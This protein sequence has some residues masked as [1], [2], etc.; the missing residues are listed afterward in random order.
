MKLTF[1]A[2]MAL[3]VFSS[4]T[5][6]SA[7]FA[8]AHFERKELVAK[9]AE[10]ATTQAARADIL[11]P[12]LYVIEARLIATQA[13]EGTMRPEAAIER[14]TELREQQVQAAKGWRKAA[15]EGTLSKGAAAALGPLLGTEAA[16][17]AAEFWKVVDEKILPALNSTDGEEQS[18]LLAVGIQALEPIFNAHQ[19]AVN[20]ASDELESVAATADQAAKDAVSQADVRESVLFA[21][22]LVVVSGI[23][24]LLTRSLWRQVGAEPAELARITKLIAEGNLGARLAYDPLPGS[25]AGSI[26]SMRL[27]LI[28]VT[29]R[30]RTGADS[31]ALAASQIAAGNS[32]LSARTENQAAALEQV[33]AAATSLLSSVSADAAN[34]REVAAKAGQLAGRAQ[35]AGDKAQAAM[36]AVAQAAAQTQAIEEIVEQIKLLSFQTNLLSLNAAVEAARAGDQ[37]RG[38]AVVA[39]EVRRLSGATDQAAKS[40]QA[41]AETSKRALG[42][43]QAETQEAVAEVGQVVG[44]VRDVSDEV[45]SVSQAAVEASNALRESVEA[46]AHLDALTQQNAALVEETSAASDHASQQATGLRD[47]VGVF[48]Q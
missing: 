4:L 25:I 36:V 10:L 9:S 46:L 38:F 5:A 26:R 48:R 27:S 3:L 45:Q 2:Q 20:A 43:A 24:L 41:L 14:L 35:A 6:M 19:T 1:R 37:G 8:S 18:V 30:I 21:V 31:V 32:D 12:P 39:Q 11:P 44:G 28:D 17:P 42:S 23:A 47:V 15:A 29:A 33:R 13:Y 7:M 22:M 16:A 34:T 40:I